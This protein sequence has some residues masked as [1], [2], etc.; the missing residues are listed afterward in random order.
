[1]P[2]PPGTQIRSSCG[3]SAK[4]VSARIVMPIAAR[5]GPAS[6]HTRRTSVS[7]RPASTSQGPVR[8]SW[9]T[10]GKSR[11]PTRKDEAIAHLRQTRDRQH[12]GAAP[13]SESL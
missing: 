8:S 6:F 11:N 5:T 9:V 1:M 2:G 10:S 12:S 13:A 3:H 7:G 4:A